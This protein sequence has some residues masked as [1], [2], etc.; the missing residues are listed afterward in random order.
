MPLGVCKMGSAPS[1]SERSNPETE[2]YQAS[3]DGR[4]TDLDEVLKELRGQERKRVLETKHKDGDDFMTPLIIAARNGNLDVVEILLR[5]DANIEARGTVKIDDEVFEGFTPL[6]GA[7]TAGHIDVLKLLIKKKAEVDGKLLTDS[8]PLRCAAYDGRLDIV[9]CLVENGANVNACKNDKTSPLFPACSNGHINVVE[10]LIKHGANVNVQ[11][12]NG[13]TAL[14]D[15]AKQGHNEIAHKLLS[16]KALQLQNVHGLTPLLLASNNCKIELVEYFIKRPECTKEQRIDALEL[17]GA[18]IANDPEHY[19]I[20]KAFCY[21]KRGMEERFKDRLHPLLKRQMDPLEVYENRKES[22][23]LKELVLLKGDDR[24]IHMEGLMIRERILGTDNTMLRIPIRYRGAEFAN[25]GDFNPCVSLWCHALKITRRC[26][27]SA[28]EDLENLASLFAQILSEKR[29]FNIKFIEEVFEQLVLEF[30]ILTEE[31]EV[32]KHQIKHK[33]AIAMKEELERL[34]YCALY[35]LMMRTKVTQPKNDERLRSLD[36]LKRLINLHPCNRDGDTLLHLA[37]SYNTAVT[38]LNVRSVCKFPC[39][40]TMT[41]L[42]LGGFDVNAVNSKGDTPL[43]VAVAFKPSSKETDTLKAMLQLLLNSGA[44]P[45][46]ENTDGLTAIDYCTTEDARLILSNLSGLDIMTIESRAVSTDGSVLSFNTR[47][48]LS[49]SSL[50]AHKINHASMVVNILK[51][52][53][54]FNLPKKKL[55]GQLPTHSDFYK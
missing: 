41:L 14:H 3:R 5:Y 46:L 7:T 13:N 21:L 11:D 37:A 20:K 25:S 32:G 39:V 26:N 28:I 1:H 24:M 40:K 19:D 27:K 29:V 18:T 4:A 42:L 35:L 48:F 55:E 6:W 8:T 45:R 51:E 38:D 16:H 30:E 10:F 36:F 47:F 34:T 50:I 12:R 22:Q 43:H 49:L 53:H 44:D 2:V 23:T 52:K 17:L 54:F 31:L 9:S 15:A 33:D